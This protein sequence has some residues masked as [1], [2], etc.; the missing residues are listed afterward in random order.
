MILPIFGKLLHRSTGD[1]QNQ[2]AFHRRRKALHVA[3][4]N[5]EG[6]GSAD[7]FA[8]K[9][10]FQIVADRPPAALQIAASVEAQVGIRS[11]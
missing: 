11:V 2:L 5:H 7:D 10:L 6:A 1:L 9:R 8:L 3:G 4:G